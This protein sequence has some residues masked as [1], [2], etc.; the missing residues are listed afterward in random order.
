MEV[1]YDPGEIAKTFHT[2]YSKFY[3]LS[4]QPESEGKKD[5]LEEIRQYMRETAIPSLS[6]ETIKE[7]EKDISVKEL[8]Q[9][10]SALAKARAQTD[11][12][13]DSIRSFRIYSLPF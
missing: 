8:Q 4:I 3:N 5:H 13:Q 2:C 10:I 12:P 1:T 11:I 9:A 6:K 7:L